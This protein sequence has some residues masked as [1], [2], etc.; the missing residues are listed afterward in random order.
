MVDNSN[1]TA[2]CCKVTT[3]LFLRKKR[4]IESV[5]L[6]FQR[7]HLVSKRD[8]FNIEKTFGLDNIQRHP[9]DQDSLLHGSKN[10]KEVI[11]LLYF[12]NCKVS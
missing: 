4:T 9:N 2:K 3:R 11:I 5:G 1:E 10:E 7:E 8:L 6:E 12:T